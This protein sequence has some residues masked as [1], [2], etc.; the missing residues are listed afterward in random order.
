[1]V[2]PWPSSENDPATPMFINYTYEIIIRE[3]IRSQR[4]SLR[5]VKVLQSF[6]FENEFSSVKPLLFV[7]RIIFLTNN[8][9]TPH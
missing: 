8:L 6:T 2:G 5:F 7:K 3:W 1:M 4:I 9:I